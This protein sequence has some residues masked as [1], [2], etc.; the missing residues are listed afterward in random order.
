MFLF[1]QNYSVYVPSPPEKKGLLE[2]IVQQ[3]VTWSFYN[4]YIMN[5]SVSRCLSFITI[6]PLHSCPIFLRKYVHKPSIAT[7]VALFIVLCPNPVPSIFLDTYFQLIDIFMGSY[8]NKKN[9]NQVTCRSLFYKC[10]LV[11]IHYFSDWGAGGI[12]QE[13]LSQNIQSSFSEQSLEY[14]FGL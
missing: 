14:H 3:R 6:L 4:S 2:T 5:L 13:P 1:L 11:V 8:A 7:T 10:F 9:V 12:F